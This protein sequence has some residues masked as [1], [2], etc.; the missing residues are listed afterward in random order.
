MMY[1]SRDSFTG[2]SSSKELLTWD[3]VC[4][5]GLLWERMIIEGATY[6]A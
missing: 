4:F 6:L 5:E 3:D 2:E 1:A